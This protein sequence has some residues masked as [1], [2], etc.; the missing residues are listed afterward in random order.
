MMIT[1]SETLE[2]GFNIKLQ[3][4]NPKNTPAQND[5]Y[6][7]LFLDDSQKKLNYEHVKDPFLLKVMNVQF[8]ASNQLGVRS[9][10]FFV[11][12][13]RKAVPRGG[14][15]EVYPPRI[16]GFKAQCYG[17]H[18]VGL[19]TKPKCV[20]GNPLV[21]IMQYSPLMANEAYAFSVGVVNPDPESVVER[22]K[23]VWGLVLKSEEGVILD[24]NMAIPGMNL[25]EPFGITVGLVSWQSRGHAC[26][27]KEKR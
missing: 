14:K 18:V 10:G 21:L 7:R 11:F 17:L 24:A 1:N 19:P 20:K 27:T 16:V 8:K 26:A 2:Q 4:K 15:I 13:G 12:T 25:M 6:M 3:V 22:E 23:N 9:P 5:W